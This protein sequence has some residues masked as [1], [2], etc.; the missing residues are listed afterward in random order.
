MVFSRPTK[1]QARGLVADLV[2]R[3][4][5]GAANAERPGSDYLESQ[6]R[7]DFIDAFLRALGWDV[8]NED[9]KVHSGRDVVVERSTDL[10]DDSEGTGRPDYILRYKRQPKHV[11]EAKKPSVRLTQPRPARQARTYGWSLSLPV[12]VVTN[13][14]ET[15]FYDARFAPLP[16]DEVSVA[17]MPDCRFV[18]TDYLDR[19]DRLWELLSFESIETGRYDDVYKYVEHPRGQSAFDQAFLSQLRDWRSLL[20]TNIAA[21]NPALGAEEVGRR[22]QR[23]LNALVFL[24]VC[25]DRHIEQY[26]DLLEAAATSRLIQ[27]FRSA[28]AIYNAGVF[29][30]LDNT[31]VEPETLRSVVQS[32]YWPNSKYAFGLI[33][34]EILA[35]IYE[36]FL[37][38]RIE[39]AEDRSVFI[40]H[41]PELTHSGG[42][43]PTPAFIVHTLLDE[44]LL[45]QLDRSDYDNLQTLT[46]LDMSCGS[47]VFLVSAFAMLLARYEEL[48]GTLTVHDRA[49]IAQR[50]L[51]GVDVDAEAVEVTRFSILLAV[52]GDDHIEAAHE[53]PVLPD[54]SANV[55]VGNS[56]VDLSFD[57]R[58][59]EAASD[60][61]RRVKVKPF[62]WKDTFPQVL[63]PAGEGPGGFD[64]IVGNPPYQRIQTLAQFFPD[65][66]AFLQDPG[67][68]YTSSVAFNF[69]MYMVFLEQGL[70]LLNSTTGRLGYIVPNRLMS[71]PPGADLRNALG[72]RVDRIVDFGICQVF[73]GRT[74][75]TC[76]LIVGEGASPLVPITTVADLAAWRA[77]FTQTI[78]NK[79]RTEL[80]RNPWTYGDNE[81]LIR[82]V[83]E[84]CPRTL[85]NVAEVFVGV[86][87]S[88]DDIFL[89]HP[90]PEST[91]DV[92]VFRDA[93]GRRREIERSITRP[94]IRDRTLV[95]YDCDPLA[96]AV[97]IFPYALDFS[98]RPPKAVVL[99]E[100]SLR[101]DFPKAAEY[102]ESFEER[103]SGRAVSPDPGSKY[104]AYGRSQSLTKLNSPKIIVRVLSLE[105]QYALDR[106]GLVV[107]GGGDGGPYYLLRPT[108]EWEHPIEVL[109]ALLSH[110]VIDSIVAT[111]GRHYRGGY[112][113]HR[114]AYLVGLPVPSVSIEDS[115]Q[116]TKMVREMHG[117]V[118]ALR[119]ECDSE[120]AGTTRARIAWLRSETENIISR[121][122][123]LNLEDEADLGV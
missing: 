69:D 4:A 100:A 6:V 82:R 27:R 31:I 77:G 89:I 34:P 91:D 41:K 72:R 57:A 37:G 113:V 16:G 99:D 10:A 79:P 55:V 121:C 47:G 29:S 114:K 78:Q 102:L 112:F 104:W 25:E 19:F 3:Y 110:P 68:R 58:F 109:I 43:V 107:P 84:H 44:T 123:G 30:I 13:F 70:R 46:I 51:Y 23:L 85:D 24:R 26:Q 101:A 9:G 20:A 111:E 98:R 76:L 83:R 62:S 18:Y 50:H 63:T 115:R 86:Q 42:V 35:W 73:P 17:E 60:P 93:D 22:T 2:A 59:P 75:Y 15:V 61:L 12:A 48:R 36:Q 65:E 8:S 45:P 32:L 96:D 120:I 1:A 94:A 118:M 21:T 88:A 49:E 67:S 105:P 40:D 116:I 5:S 108:P 39:V 117:H 52:L 28:D 54:L 97:A 92:V 90:L 106:V 71:S 14:S 87:T 74:T 66:L 56:V 11:V 53:H 122:L 33:Q 80:G 119:S 7:V 95:P 64:V 38:E 103:L 81:A